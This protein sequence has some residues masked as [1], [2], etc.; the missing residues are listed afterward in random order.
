MDRGLPI[1]MRGLVSIVIPT[2]NNEE[3]IGRCLESVEAQTYKS[4]ECIIVDR[5]STDRTADIAKHYLAEVILEEGERTL[6]KNIGLKKADGEFICFI[7]SD[8]ELESQVINECISAFNDNTGGI[9]IPERSIGSSF[10]VK[11]RDFERS[12]YAGS[13]VESARFFRKELVKKVGGFDEQRIFFEERVVPE[14]IEKL[15][16]DVNRRIAS[17]IIHNEEGFSLLGWLGKKYFYG[18]TARKSRQ[19]GVTY[20]LGLFLKNRRFYSHPG[21]ALCVL[22]L[23]FLEFVSTILGMISGWMPRK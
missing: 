17:Q 1:I 12:F 13:D 15:G 19:L 2:F 6:A 20:R 8:M 11:V 10:W 23:K 4:I 22:L 3:T 5:Y 9:V 7:D 14:K 21:L 18:K 16:F